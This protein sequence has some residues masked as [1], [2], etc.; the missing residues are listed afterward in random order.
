MQK[1]L[2]VILILV[3]GSA[4]SVMAQDPTPTAPPAEDPTSAAPPE[5]NSVTGTTFVPETQPFT[6]D[7]LDQLTVPEGFEISVFAQDLGNAR[8]IEVTENGVI[9]ISR[10]MENDVIALF[11]QNGD[12]LSDIE[13]F[14]VVAADIGMAHGLT[15][16]DG[17]LYIAG[18]KEVMAADILEDGSL[19]EME[20]ITEALPDGGQHPRRTIG[21]DANDLLYISIGSTCNACI[22]PNPESAAVVRMSLGSTEREVFAEGLRNMLGFAWHPETGELWGIDQGSD[23]RGDDSPP[24]ELNL[25][26]EGN[27]YGW[28]FCYAEQQVD[29]YLPYNLEEIMGVTNEAFCETTAAPEILYQAHSSPIDFLFYTG[30][31]FPE[32]YVNDA[33]AVMR[34]S[35][36]RYPA[37]GYKVVRLHFEDGQPTEFTDFLTGFLNEEGT[38]HFAR[39]AGLAVMPDGSLLISDDTNGILYRVAYTGSEG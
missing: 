34:G 35:W 31:Q 15:I 6:Q 12:G 24:E 39:I 33:F 7:R 17:R 3:V 9:Y 27:H 37:T 13:G 30:D 19:G 14:R 4:L 2:L 5:P 28:P 26:Q 8:M 29:I 10:P 20:T 16:H 21:F 18:E 22:E 11:D 25:I 23:W 36:N 1:Y 32:D 38:A